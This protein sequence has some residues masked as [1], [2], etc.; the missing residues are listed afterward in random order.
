MAANEKIVIL[1]INGHIGQAAARAFV[2]AGW[3]VSGFGRSNREPIAGVTFIKG[4]AE[5][6]ADMKAAVA[7]VDVVFNALNL[8]YHEWDNGR[9][10]AQLQRVIEAMGSSGKTLLYPGNIY[11][12]AAS[13]RVITPDTPQHPE[14]SRGAIRV[15]SEAML[16]AAAGRGDVQVVI[17]RAGDFFAPH[18][19]GTWFD[20]AMLRDSGRGK[21][22]VPGGRDI[23]HAWAYLPDLAKAFT[24]LADRRAEL[25]AFETF[26]F[27]GHFVTHGELLAGMKVSA[28]V[29][30]QTAAFPWT[31]FKVLALFMPMIREILKMRY[32]WNNPMELKDDRLAAMLGPD[33][34]TPFDEAIAATLA[35]FF[36]KVAVA[37]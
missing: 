15:R 16:Q 22:S 18:S 36:D 32:L 5:S 3:Q 21:V 25:G 20:L 35:P 24:V 1:G 11:N 6:V 7:D 8:P 19:T 31:M 29:P 13:Q 34:G 2:E 23:G 12:Y 9:A 30:L 28:P 37:A 14:T 27:A 33:F 26:H 4:D 10:E 17:L